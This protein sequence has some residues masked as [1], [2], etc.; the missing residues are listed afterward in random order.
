MN[1]YAR[2]AERAAY[3]C[4][5]KGLNVARYRE[6]STRVSRHLHERRSILNL[7]SD[8][9]LGTMSDEASNKWHHLRLRTEGEFE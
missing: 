6:L 1:I 8:E 7:I 9:K 5:E 2:H 3:R 4:N